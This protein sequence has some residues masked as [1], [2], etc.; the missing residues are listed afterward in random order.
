MS[1]KYRGPPCWCLA[2]PF[3][4]RPGGGKC[5]AGSTV[6]GPAG[7]CSACGDAAEGSLEHG[8]YSTRWSECHGAEILANTEAN[9]KLLREAKKRMREI[10]AHQ[11]Q[12][13]VK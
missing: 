10:I 7:L 2:Y 13:G 5:P 12:R 1:G 4:H 6:E 11:E 3:P 8:G 9:A